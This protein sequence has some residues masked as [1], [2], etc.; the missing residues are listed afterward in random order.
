[1][2]Q[3]LNF[4]VELLAPMKGGVTYPRIANQASS[5]YSNAT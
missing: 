4:L 1:M 3:M 5:A 2:I